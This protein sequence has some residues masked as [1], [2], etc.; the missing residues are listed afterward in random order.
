M[1]PFGLFFLFQ[2]DLILV[3][4]DHKT[5]LVHGEHDND[6][7]DGRAMNGGCHG[8]HYVRGTANG[9]CGLGYVPMRVRTYRYSV[10]IDM[11]LLL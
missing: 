1:F 2:F 5:Y 6:N 10:D 7:H 4:C 11:L 3:D 8:L 9:K